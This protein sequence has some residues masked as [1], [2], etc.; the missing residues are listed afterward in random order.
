M[1]SHKF[2]TWQGW[3]L[4]AALCLYQPVYAA[5]L[6]S[7]SLLS[8]LGQPLAAE[9]DL[10]TVDAREWLS[11]KVSLGNA[12]HYQ[13]AGLAYNPLLRD[14]VFSIEKRADG[15]GWIRVSS[16]RMV[17]EPFLILLVELSWDG[18]RFVRDYS[19]LLD[20][21]DSTPSAATTMGMGSAKI[22]AQPIDRRISPPLASP[23]SSQSIS[24]TQGLQGSAKGAYN[25]KPGD[26]LN[27]I[28]A[29]LK[30]TGISLDQMMI[31]LLRANGDAFIE[32][33][34]N[35]LMVGKTLNVP[36]PDE[37][38]Q[39][40]SNEATK[41]TQAQVTLWNLYRQKA[42]QE[43][44]EVNVKGVD[45][46]AKS[47]AVSV[48]EKA[49]GGKDL[50][51]LSKVEN[52]GPVKSRQATVSPQGVQTPGSNEDRLHAM[53][54]DLLA[55]EKALNEAKRRISELEVALHEQHLAPGALSAPGAALIPAGLKPSVAS[56]SDGSLMSQLLQLPV[57][58]GWM[59]AAL[60]GSL[61]G[62]LLVWLGL[63]F[64]R[65]KART[66]EAFEEPSLANTD[67]LATIDLSLGAARPP[68]QPYNAQWQTCQE[69]LDLARAYR[70]MGRVEEVKEMLRFVLDQG[71]VEQKIH[72]T[73]LSQNL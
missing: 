8:H 62:S 33:N 45:S 49:Q 32:N 69:K 34:M 60:L 47:S 72:A 65:A 28:A 5:S 23:K 67:T 7:I 9:I 26:T 40:D 11:L 21:L 4:S 70:E 41:L 43:T 42:A 57:W 59:C 55:Q 56:T 13:Q 44:P 73:H 48:P 35:L 20:P 63:G 19:V 25:V 1:D 16:N 18:G 54:E 31:G 17:E 30:P 66:R 6:G 71:D 22:N 14:I 10:G 52:S 2:L 64:V 61:L 46:G 51:L 3:V 36:K 27:S 39:I 29:S 68:P 12:E 15:R 37:L 53:E 50:V 58:V 24:S 38:S